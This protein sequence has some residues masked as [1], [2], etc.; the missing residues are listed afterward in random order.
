[1]VGTRTWTMLGLASLLVIGVAPAS[2]AAQVQFTFTADLVPG[3]VGF[4]VFALLGGTAS[5][6]WVCDTS[7]TGTGTNPKTYPLVSFHFTTFT[8]VDGYMGTGST[9]SIANNLTTPPKDAYTIGGSSLSG[10]TIGGWSL[11]TLSLQMIDDDATVFSST[12]LPS[13]LN[14]SAFETAYMYASYGTGSFV[15]TSPRW[16]IT[17]LTAQIIGAKQDVDGDGDVDLSDFSVFLTCFNGPSRPWAGPSA[18]CT[19]FDVDSDKD[20]D[21]ADFGEFLTCF[22]GPARPP[23]CP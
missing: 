14:L 8:G 3:S 16:E 7:A 4:D 21:L 12:T 17:S 2:H 23:A 1:M 19:K 5:G 13:T 11:L 18:T 9:I 10:D 6:T 20:I 22:N 15:E